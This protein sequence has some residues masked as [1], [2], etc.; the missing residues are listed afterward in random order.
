MRIGREDA[1]MV[2]FRQGKLPWLDRRAMEGEGRL[3]VEA[4]LDILVLEVA[5]DM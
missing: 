2:D 1:S 5:R 4:V 3:A